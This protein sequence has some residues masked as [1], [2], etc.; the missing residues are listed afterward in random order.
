[1]GKNEF[2]DSNAFK[3]L[4][5]VYRG[6]DIFV[7][8]CSRLPATTGTASAFIFIPFYSIVDV[9]DQMCVAYNIQLWSINRN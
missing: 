5:N 3:L 6:R 4:L 2:V 1:M 8:Q 7:R 9:F